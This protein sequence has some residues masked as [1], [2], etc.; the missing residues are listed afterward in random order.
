L[1][2]TVRDVWCQL[3]LDPQT[4]RFVEERFE[5]PHGWF[6]TVAHAWLRRFVSDFDANGLLGAY[7]LHLLSTPQ[8]R[9]LLGAAPVASHLDFG[10]GN[11]DLTASL[12]PLVQ[13]TTTTERSKA[14]RRVLRSRG[15][16]C[17]STDAH[18]LEGAVDSR[19][20]DLVTC[21]NVLDRTSHPWSLLRDLE[22]RVGDDGRLVLAVPL[23]VDPFYYAGAAARA[24]I[25]A[26][27]LSGDDWERQCSSLAHAVTESQSLRLEGACRAPY[28]SGGDARRRLYVLDDAILVFRR[29]GGTAKQGRIRR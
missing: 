17:V 25:E 8:W 12:S 13:H 23:P 2:A 15:F 24:P 19:R 5:A 29:T 14:M 16:E 10:A 27:E 26:L 4:Q 6:K 7:P 11:G 28:I 18:D 9:Q 20:F 21:L 3:S 22:D 1:S